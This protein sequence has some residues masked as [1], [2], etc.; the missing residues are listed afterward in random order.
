MDGCWYYTQLRVTYNGTTEAFDRDIAGD[1]HLYIYKGEVTYADTVIPHAEF[2]NGKEITFTNLPAGQYSLVGWAASGE[3]EINSSAPEVSSGS[4]PE[5]FR[6]SL[7]VGHDEYHYPLSSLYSGNLD[8]TIESEKNTTHTIDLE[9]ALCRIHLTVHHI[10]EVLQKGGSID[11]I[12]I[13]LEGTH[14]DMD[15]DFHPQGEEAIVYHSLTYVSENDQLISGVIGTLPSSDSQRLTIKAYQND[16][17]FFEIQTDE[18]AVAGDVIY[19][20]AGVSKV[21]ITING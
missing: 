5:N 7:P 10:G 2:K 16:K 15:K 4:K 3:E 14:S 12:W 1:L 20:D 13:E 18:K 6:Y 11:N 8:F 19:I 9:N 21:T 17:P